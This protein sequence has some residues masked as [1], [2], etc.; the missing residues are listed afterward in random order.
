MLNLSW[1]LLF[2]PLENGFYVID[3][4]TEIL[5]IGTIASIISLCTGKSE[6]LRTLDNFSKSDIYAG[7]PYR[8]KQLFYER[9]SKSP[10]SIALGI[11]NVVNHQISS[12]F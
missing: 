2:S 5:E 6:I 1:D 3:A 10:T 11:N 4:C 7:S 9:F 12:K 8:F